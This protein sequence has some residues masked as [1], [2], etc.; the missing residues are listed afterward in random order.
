MPPVPLPRRMFA[1]GRIQF[2]KPIRIGEK[3]RRTGRVTD[4]VAK[5]GRAGQLVFASV[6]QEIEGE[7][8]LALVEEQDIVCREHPRTP[9]ARLASEPPAALEAEQQRTVLPDEAM[10]FRYS[11]LLFNAHRIDRKSPR[12]N[13]SH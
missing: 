13:S 5:R 9:T 7:D 3:A 11:A 8:G 10:L 1:G 6:R 4:R 2:L 12:L